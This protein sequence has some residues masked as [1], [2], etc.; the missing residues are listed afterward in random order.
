MV[1]IVL[2]ILPQ[3]RVP[4]QVFVQRLIAWSPSEIAS[5]ERVTVTEYDWPLQTHTREEVNFSRSEGSVVLV[6]FWASWCPPCIAE[7]P[8]LQKLHNDYGDVVD[9]YFVTTEELTVVNQFLQKKSYQLPVYVSGQRPPAAMDYQSLPT[10]FLIS[11][12]GK[13]VMRKEGA[14][15]WNSEKVRETIAL[16]LAE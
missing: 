2:L 10:T 13:I 9:F 12:E 16:L 14:A 5:E 6:N 4:I 11:K 1:A 8:S 7:M 15:D 3:T